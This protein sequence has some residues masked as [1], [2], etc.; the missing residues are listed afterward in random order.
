MSEIVGYGYQGARYATVKPLRPWF[1]AGEEALSRVLLVD[2]EPAKAAPGE[3]A[4]LLRV[5]WWSPGEPPAC[6]VLGALA[7]LLSARGLQVRGGA[8]GG[9]AGGMDLRE[10]A[11]AV[12]RA[13]FAAVEEVADAIDA[14]QS[15]AA[16][17]EAAELMAA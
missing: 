2:D 12:S 17:R 11:A 1:G 10:A 3:E 13:L 15:A 9:A 7:R 14:E 8:A 5:P 6:G 16:E 4:N